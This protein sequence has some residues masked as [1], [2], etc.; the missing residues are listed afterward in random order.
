MLKK[1]N[2]NEQSDLLY[3]LFYV[4]LLVVCKTIT[5]KVVNEH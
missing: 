3:E 4:H 2:E 5:L 1:K